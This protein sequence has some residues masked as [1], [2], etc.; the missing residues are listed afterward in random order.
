M[1]SL[2]DFMTDLATNPAQQVAFTQNPEAVMQQ[3]GLAEADQAILRSG[4]QA[5]VTAMY[6]DELTEPSFCIMDPNPDPM[7]DPDPPP[8][9]KPSEEEEEQD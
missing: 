7:P 5:E 6:A 3:A 4:N 9:P 8:I 1:S 2:F